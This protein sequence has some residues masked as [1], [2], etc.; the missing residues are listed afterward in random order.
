MATRKTTAKKP[1]VKKTTAKKSANDKDLKKSMKSFAG[2]YSS[3]LKDFEEPTH[4]LDKDTVEFLRPKSIRQEG[5]A[6]QFAKGMLDPI[7]S[8]ALGGKDMLSNLGKWWKTG[9]WADDEE[10][11][12][13]DSSKDSGSGGLDEETK[14]LFK[15][16]LPALS[17]SRGLLGDIREELTLIR[18]LTE[19]S[20]KLD[21]SDKTGSTYRDQLTGRK[22]SD[23]NELTDGGVRRN[24]AF[25]NANFMME[26]ITADVNK[27]LDRIDDLDKR[28]SDL[29]NQFPH[30]KNDPEI[31]NQIKVLKD[32][33]DSE[34]LANQKQLEELERV[35][36]VQQQMLDSIIKTN[37][38]KES[39]KRRK[40][41]MLGDDLT[42]VAAAQQQEATISAAQGDGGLGL[43]DILGSGADKAGKAGKAGKA[44]SAAGGFMGKAAR[45]MGGKGG[46]IGAGVLGAIGGG[47]VAYDRITEAQE[48]EEAAKQQAREDL[49]A[50]KITSAQYNDQVQQASDKATIS[51]ASGAG[52]GLGMFGGAMAGAKAGAVLGTAFGGPIGTVV[53]GLAGG[54]LGAFGGSKLGSWLGEKVGGMFT[55]SK[56]AS[57]TT[58][59]SGSFSVSENGQTTTGEMIDGKYY[60]NGQEVTEKDYQAVREKLGVAKASANAQNLM[61]G[62]SNITDMQPI[63]KSDALPTGSTLQNMSM[64]NRELSAQTQPTV[65]NNVTNNNGGGGGSNTMVAPLKPAVRPDQSTLTRYLDRVMAY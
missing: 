10:T 47:I 51:K 32:F 61:S 39:E 13:D 55:G 21:K 7:V 43:G 31:K 42:D 8:S 28:I 29:K 19:G 22:V 23:M 46:V 37:K 41:G 18:R 33:R 5:S 48:T 20:L 17:L 25:E 34:K 50:G 3:P 35:R 53:G 24:E 6:K 54:A 44:A 16:H 64:Q 14:R 9:Q 40:S 62:K 15:T 57:S 58:K 52:E 56:P 38:D 63:S 26:S 60:I 65:I 36:E 27:R 59:Q 4:G 2:Q 49:A 30:M 1:T 11:K 45:F 12:K